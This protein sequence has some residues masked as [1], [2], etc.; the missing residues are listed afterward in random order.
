MVFLEIK[1]PPAKAG[2][3][4]NTKVEKITTSTKFLTHV[5]LEKDYLDGKN[6]R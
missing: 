5:F 6:N 2:D 1:T 3:V 4:T